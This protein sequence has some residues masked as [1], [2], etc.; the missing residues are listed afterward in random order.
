MLQNVFGARKNHHCLKREDKPL[1][2]VAVDRRSNHATSIQVGTFKRVDAMLCT[3][4]SALYTYIPT[5]HATNFVHTFNVY[6]EG[7]YIYVIHYRRI[8]ILEHSTSAYM[9]I[10]N[11][12]DFYTSCLC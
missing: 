11:M 3:R 12:N 10:G 9:Y 6:S 1:N 7:S 8:P 4:T 5:S 2:G